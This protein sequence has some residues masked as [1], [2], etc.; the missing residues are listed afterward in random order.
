MIE[1]KAGIFATPKKYTQKELSRKKMK[2][3]NS[4]YTNK[5][6]KSIKSGSESLTSGF[7]ES[8]EKEN[9]KIAKQYNRRIREKRKKLIQKQKQSTR[10]IKDKI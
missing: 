5:T 3:I 7:K 1:K 9:K 6:F 10:E 2:K 4:I 8:D